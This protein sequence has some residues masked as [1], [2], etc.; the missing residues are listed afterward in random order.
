MDRQGAAHIWRRY[1]FQAAHRLPN[2]PAGHKCGRMHGHG[3]AVM[4]HAR[5]KAGG[6]GP[7]V[8]YDHL[9]R[10]WAPWQQQLDLCCL[11]DLEGL[12]NPTSE[13]LSFWL[14]TR[15]QP[16]LPALAWVTVFETGTCGANFDGRHYRIWKE[17]TLDSAVR[18]RRAPAGNRLGGIHG[19]TF[20]LRLHL[21]APIDEVLGWTMDFGDVKA[22]FDPSFE[23][24][25][26]RP[27]YEIAGLVDTDAASLAD[28]IFRTVRQDL[29]QLAG[30]ELYES[31]GCGAFYCADA[32]GPPL[33]V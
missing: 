10:I 2:V 12:D 7:D 13:V 6:A 17:F 27:L 31:P 5:A 15:L 9:D 32:G 3:F 8:D 18:L 33:P 24:L 28:W 30:V 1:E 19:H 4:L 23:A 29:P 25:D 21:S 11:N 26:H 14:W 22:V 20:K 16:A